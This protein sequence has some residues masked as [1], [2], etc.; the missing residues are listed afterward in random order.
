MV[1][2]VRA[3]TESYPVLLEQ[4][5]SNLRSWYGRNGRHYLPWRMG[6]TPWK[7]L[8]AEVLLHRTKAAAVERLYVK[9]SGQFPSA[10][11]IVQQPEKWL[12]ATRPVG[13]G[14]RSRAFVSA[15]ENLV[16]LY[17]GEVPVSSRALMSLPGTG[18]YIASAVRCFGFGLPQVVVDT[19]TIRIAARVTRVAL[20]I[21]QHR[22]GKVKQSVAKLSEDGEAS[23]PQDNY[24]LL[25]LAAMVCHRVEPKC[26]HCPIITACETGRSLVTGQIV[27]RES[28]P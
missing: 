28:N 19:N 6:A 20:D 23:G 14:W 7:I 10:L 17:G 8:L 18:H 11:A 26:A 21:T 1:F 12:A 5:W 3:P 2:E 27:A 22:S 13:L 16:T 4:D 9:V 24:A 15:C 25:D